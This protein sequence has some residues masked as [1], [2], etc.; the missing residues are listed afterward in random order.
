[1]G[2]TSV[3]I[4]DLRDG[5][6]VARASDTYPFGMAISSVPVAAWNLGEGIEALDRHG[7]HQ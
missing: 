4:M 5:R 1:M 3:R 6:V 2:A 7:P